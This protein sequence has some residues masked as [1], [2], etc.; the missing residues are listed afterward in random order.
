MTCSDCSA[1]AP[2]D[3]LLPSTYLFLLALS[4]ISP[5]L[6]YHSLSLLHPPDKVHRLLQKHS[7]S[8]F[9]PA[10]IES[11]KTVPY[12]TSVSDLGFTFFI[13]E[14][15]LFDVLEIKIQSNAYLLFEEVDI[16]LEQRSF[17]LPS[18]IELVFIFLRSLK[19]CKSTLFLTTNRV[20]NISILKDC[21]GLICDGSS[22]R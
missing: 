3:D 22:L 2:N 11:I 14:S 15:S 13:I 19:Y 12:I 8:S 7:D 17:I 21:S 20:N 9:Q 16:F 10:V 1:Q 6:S 5:S 4:H 18:E